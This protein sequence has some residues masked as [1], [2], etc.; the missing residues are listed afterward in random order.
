MFY[1]YFTVSSLEPIENW[2]Y[3][4]LKVHKHEMVLNFFYPKSKLC[5]SRNF[6]LLWAIYLNALRS[7]ESG[8]SLTCS[9]H[10]CSSE[11]RGLLP[12]LQGQTERRDN[13]AMPKI[14]LV[15]DFAAGVSSVL[16][17]LPPITPYSPLSH[18]VRVQYTYS[19]KGGGGRANKREG[20]GAI[21]HKSGRK[22]QHDWLYLQSINS[23]K[24]K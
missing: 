8:G 3:W 10:S 2:T 13:V 6:P 24:H 5:R 14:W 12:S 21:I 17:P 1:C 19:H 22:Y 16:G 23:I 4:H 7:D 9:L 11:E 18:C 20:R 15:R